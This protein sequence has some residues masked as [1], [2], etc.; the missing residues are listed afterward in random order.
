MATYD[1]NKDYM[2]LRN[3]A[4]ASGDYKLAAQY[5][6]QRNAKIDGEGISTQQKTYDYAGNLDTNDYASQLQRMMGAGA[7]ASD[8]QSVLNQRTDKANNAVNLRK[9]AYDDVYGAAMNYINNPKPT[10]TSNYADQIASIMKSI[11]DNQNFSYDPAT[12]PLYSNYKKQYLREADRSASDTLGQAAALTGGIPSTAAVSAAS[13]AADYQKTQ[14]TDK[15]PELEQAAYDMYKDQRNDRYNQLSALT[16]LES[17]DYQKYQDALSQYDTNRA[18]NYGVNQDTKSAALTASDTDYQKKAAQADNLAQ[19]GDFSGY[20]ALGYTDSQI[21]AMKKQWQTE[22]AQKAAKKSSTG[23]GSGY[24]GGSQN[25][26][27]LFASAQNA[28]SPQN[29]IS[30]N[31][32]KY[33][34]TSSSGL[35]SAYQQWAN[36]GTDATSLN[37][38]EDS[39]VFKWNG[40]QYSSAEKLASAIE[41]AGLTSSQKQALSKKFSLYGFDISFN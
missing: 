30:S 15:I 3:A 25:Y 39:G 32:K 1:K 33:G 22:Q 31:Y 19:Y 4:A 17:S 2:A 40:K 9:Y 12:D 16:S 6:D 18:Y 21:A 5:E 14:L 10:Y 38:D 8:V 26:D 23:T 41:K 34:F 7:S 13:Q 20:K 29:F 35:W 11:Q 27:G 28:V 36:N 37:F 24:G